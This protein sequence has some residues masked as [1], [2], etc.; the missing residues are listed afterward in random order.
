MHFSSPI[1]YK[2]HKD[3][4]FMYKKNHLLKYNIKNMFLDYKEIIMWITEFDVEFQLELIL[5]TISYFLDFK[6]IQNF[7]IFKIRN[8][9]YTWFYY[10]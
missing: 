9:L 4:Q 7:I 8:F 6:F 5:Y 3:V 2:Y 1:K 10:L